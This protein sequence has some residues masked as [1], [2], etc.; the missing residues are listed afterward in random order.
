VKVQFGVAITHTANGKVNSTNEA[1][2]CKGLNIMP[3]L[4]KLDGLMPL[5]V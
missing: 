5:W 2:L 4:S 3:T 1:L